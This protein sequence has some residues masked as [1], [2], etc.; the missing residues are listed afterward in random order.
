MWM[1]IAKDS[2]A[3]TC[4]HSH[5]RFSLQPP[6]N[7]PSNARLSCKWERLSSRSLQREAGLRDCTALKT[8]AMSGW[9]KIL[10]LNEEVLPICPHP[11]CH[12]SLVPNS[13]KHIDV[14]DDYHIN[15]E[16]CSKWSFSKS[17]LSTSTLKLIGGSGGDSLGHPKFRFTT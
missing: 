1:M 6:N 3:I 15:Y 8:R 4:H 10:F 9:R 14:K 7:H 2:Q 13:M 16:Q 17:L 5:G 12:L 11:R